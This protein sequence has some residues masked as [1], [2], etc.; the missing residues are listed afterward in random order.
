VVNTVNG[1]LSMACLP[2]MSEGHLVNG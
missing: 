1:Q 2:G